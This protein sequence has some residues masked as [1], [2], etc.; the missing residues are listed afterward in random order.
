[1]RRRLADGGHDVTLLARG[2]RLLQL[3]EHGVVLENARSGERTTTHVSLT[4]V[5]EPEDAYD[6]V[7]V[8][9]RRHQV[10]GHPARPGR[11]P[12]NAHRTLPR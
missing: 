11:E 9:M 2:R 4:G 10:P 5:L 1:M 7:L 6:L 3:Q 8:A 12:A